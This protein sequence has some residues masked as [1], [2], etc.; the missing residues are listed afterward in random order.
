[1]LTGHFTGRGFA[2]PHSRLAMVLGLDPDCSREQF[3]FEL[4]SRMQTSLKPVE[5]ATGSCKEVVK[6]GKDA[7]LFDL[8][9]PTYAVGDGGRYSLTQ[10]HICKDPDSDW[11]NWANYRA[12]LYSRNRYAIGAQVGSQFDEIFIAKYEPRG[13]SMPVATVIGADPAVFFVAGMELPPGVS[14]ADVAGGIRKAPMELVRCETSD[15]LVPAD[16]EVVI[17]GEVRPGEFLPEGP[18]T[19]A[20]LFQ[21]SPRLPNYAVRV[22]CI[23]HRK[24]PI[25]PILPQ[26]PVGDAYSFYM[27]TYH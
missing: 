3:A 20:S 17:E 15:L 11:V 19:E 13:Q 24:Y 7:N 14:E 4:L 8:P 22:N 25:I 2:S 18:L 10:A 1:M 12:M 9:F 21:A 5:V 6:M 27:S 26:P 16:A 23:T